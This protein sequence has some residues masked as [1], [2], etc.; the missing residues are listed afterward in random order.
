MVAVVFVNPRMKLP[1]FPPLPHVA[2]VPWSDHN[3]QQGLVAWSAIDMD[4]YVSQYVDLRVV[5]LNPVY[6]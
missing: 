6:S 1:Q 2:G 5:A 3:P 4:P